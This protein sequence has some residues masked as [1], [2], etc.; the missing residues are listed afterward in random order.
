[1]LKNINQSILVHLENGI[2]KEILLIGLRKNLKKLK[3]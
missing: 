3:N 2:D 1:M